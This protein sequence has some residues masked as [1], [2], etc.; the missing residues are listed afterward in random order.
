[1]WAIMCVC[2][3]V[4]HT[5]GRSCLSTG[6]ALNRCFGFLGP[7][8]CLRKGGAGYVQEPEVAV[9]H[10]PVHD[11]DSILWQTCAICACKV[12]HPHIPPDLKGM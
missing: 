6:W 4:C 8:P 12:V 11:P 2:H 1:M 9:V 3:H 5:Q 7:W 10:H